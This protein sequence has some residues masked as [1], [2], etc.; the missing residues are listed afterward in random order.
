MKLARQGKSETEERTVL[1]I[2]MLV[3]CLTFLVFFLFLSRR[4]AHPPSRKAQL[5]AQL[6]AMNAAIELFANEFDGYP[7]SDPNDPVGQPYCGAMKLTE[8]VMGQDLLGFH[9]QSIFRRDGLDAEGASLYPPDLDKLPIALRDANLK[10][11]KG[12]FLQVEYANAWRL[13]DVYGEGNTGPFAESTFVLCDPYEQVRPSGERTGM[14]ILYYRADSSGTAHD[15]ANPD[16]PQNIYHYQ[17]NQALILLGVLGEPNQVHPLA[18]PQ[19]FYLNT[20]D[21]K[22][23][24]RPASYRR[25]SFILVSA[26]EDGL[27]GTADDICNFDWKYRKR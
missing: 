16:N 6:N 23:S 1:A 14:P 3:S 21:R 10:A 18:D 8:A 4:R 9:S 13:V 11:R 27:Y 22:A 2:L 17:D 12:P 25:D 26:G 7:P 15:V 5:L 20:Q 19:R 24:G